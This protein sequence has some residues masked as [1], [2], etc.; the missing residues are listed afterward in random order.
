MGSQGNLYITL[1]QLPDPCVRCPPCTATRTQVVSSGEGAPPE[2]PKP[3]PCLGL[4]L[5]E[6]ASGTSGPSGFG[7]LLHPYLSGA[8]APPRPSVGVPGWAGWAGPALQGEGGWGEDQLKSKPPLPSPPRRTPA[9]PPRTSFFV[10]MFF[11]PVK[12]TVQLEPGPPASI[13]ADV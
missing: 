5:G 1:R 9:E 13:F 2:P 7:D 4:L 11:N 8:A 3:G 6:T 10:T 12:Q